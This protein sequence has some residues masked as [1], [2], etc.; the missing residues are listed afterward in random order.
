MTKKQAASIVIRN[1]Q[2][3]KTYLVFTEKQNNFSEIQGAISTFIKV[4]VTPEAK[5][6]IL[7]VQKN[8]CL[9]LVKELRKYF[10]KNK[11]V[12]KF[13][14]VNLDYLPTR[15]HGQYLLNESYFSTPT[16]ENC[17]WAGLLAADG[18]I[19]SR[20]NSSTVISLTL[21]KQDQERLEL[22]MEA[23]SATSPVYYSKR[24]KCA[25][26]ELTS[27]KLANDL[28]KHWNI[29][30]RKSL[31][32]QPPNIKNKE[33]IKAFLVGLLDGDG[34]IHYHKRGYWTLQFLIGTVQL[35]T[36][37]NEFLKIGK[38]KLSKHGNI[39]RLQYSCSPALTVAKVLST[40]DV[41]R[42]P[43]KWDKILSE[44]A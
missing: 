19:K 25:V 29:G 15:Y 22:F 3:A 33:M 32:I 13:E 9:R 30:P 16:I 44:I 2:R 35:G 11:F 4:N 21:H 27:D 10:P 42:M 31:T 38:V 20:K 5:T 8:S 6:H 40:V 24:S 18:C 41:P 17:Y 23:L 1:I 34:C 26:I 43:R 12:Q 37:V 14:G 39:F 7:K 28:W 36:W